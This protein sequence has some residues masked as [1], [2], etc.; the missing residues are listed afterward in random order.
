[1]VAGVSGG[2]SSWA[3][4]VTAC[5]GG[6][7][8]RVEHDMPFIGGVEEGARGFAPKEKEGREEV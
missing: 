4:A 1:M 5:G 6:G 7:L 8:A 3:A 2:A